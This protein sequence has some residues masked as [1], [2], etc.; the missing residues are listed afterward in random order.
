M[1]F[2]T[3]LLSGIAQLLEDTGQGTWKP[4]GAYATDDPTPIIIKSVPASP[5]RVITLS[6]Y[7]V[8]DDPTLSDSV[9][10]LQVRFRAGRDPRT[11]D[12]MA[13]DAFDVLHGLQGVELSTGVLIVQSY[14]QSSALLGADDNGRHERSDNYYLTV[15]RPSTHRT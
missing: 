7:S 6:E 14:R 15:H 4:T 3:D 8:S 11:V 12:D 9:K 10:G 2:T 5:D 1:S 13:D